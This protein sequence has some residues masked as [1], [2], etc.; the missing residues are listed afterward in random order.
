MKSFKLGLGATVVALAL[1]GCQT[2]LLNHNSST[3]GK[4]IYV[5]QHATS[6]THNGS[7][8]NDAYVN[9]QNALANAKAGDQIWVS[10]G[11]YYPTN[12]TDRNDSFKMVKGVELL[13]GFAGT[14][15]LV[16]Q[17]NWQ[18]NKTILSGNIGD[19]N[20]QQDN[21]YHVVIGANNAVL[22]GFVIEDGYA[23]GGLPMMP[24][25]KANQ[26]APGK[27]PINHTSP[28]AILSGPSN[29]VGAGLLN[30]QVA[31]VV[32][33]TIF[34]NNYAM[35]GGAVYNM[36]STN[37]QPS[38]SNPSPV[39]INTTFS[40]NFAKLRGGAVSNDLWTDPIFINS[41]F[42]SN[43]TSD[44]GGAM[45][46]DFGS[47][48]VI[49]NSQFSKNQA[50]RAGAFGVDGS[51]RP[52]LVNV[53]IE[54]NQVSDL[55][56]GIYQG[57]YNAGDKNTQNI[58]YLIDSKL[59]NNHSATNGSGNWMNWGDD[60]IKNWGSE[61]GNW[62]YGDTM[63]VQKQKEFAPLVELS[64]TLQKLP[65]D[66][67]AKGQIDSI[68]RFVQHIP[69]PQGPHKADETH[70]FGIDNP[71]ITQ[72]NV[73]SNVIY[74]NGK[75]TNTTQDGKTWNTAFHTLQAGID[76]AS[77]DGGQIWL[78]EGTYYPAKT[79]RAKSFVI[80]SGVAVYGG[81]KGDETQWN[82]RNWRDYHSILSGNI[83]NTKSNKDNSYHVVIGGKG[84]LIDGVTIQ[85]GYADGPARQGYGGGL[86]SWGYDQSLL[87]KNTTFKDNYAREGGAAFFF[88]NSRSDLNNVIF[89]N[90]K[91]E[92]GG[93]VA[94]RFGSSI[95]IDNSTFKDNSS[96]DRAGALLINY[97]SNVKVKDSL[98]TG[99]VT[100]GNGGAIWVDDQ[101]SQYG[102]TYPV[103][104]GTAFVKNHADYYGGAIHNFNKS[105]LT[106]EESFFDGNTSQF[107]SS[108][109]NTA[110][111][112][113]SIKNTQIPSGTV[114]KAADT[115]S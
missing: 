41:Q 82:Q 49:I 73:S 106:V 90:N 69:V 108:I 27:G 57:S 2:D 72:V 80:P 113:L 66:A 17:R 5:D 95:E 26:P 22:D 85:D 56:A 87:V 44:K 86:L 4:V 97:G 45:Y 103:I 96:T 77:K 65:A 3:S 115:Q 43:S 52:V 28:N 38:D 10:E 111:S 110:G 46:N 31:P 20:N 109:A 63:S 36:T 83:G 59:T 50:M 84:A 7:S 37:P 89:E 12:G 101:A 75:A 14:E 102:G 99:N 8:W 39:F 68:K 19:K 48:P 23:V 30:Y 21:S 58:T 40:H 11:T 1:A 64:K 88:Q 54:N 32:R 74:V 114:Y 78:A 100:S 76:A 107:G 98:F 47:S 62:H 35:K 18:K 70:T 61:I 67:I 93:A 42:I 16:T 112:V 94:A 55:G 91:A 24:P 25:P 51:S 6:G 15:T 60:T 33:N 92:F 29:G 9:L 81:F 104:T 79:D 105:T 34:E 13:G 53:S 71:V